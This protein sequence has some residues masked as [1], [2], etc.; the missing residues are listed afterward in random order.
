MSRLVLHLAGTVP[1]LLLTIVAACGGATG[2]GGSGVH[3]PLPEHPLGAPGP[4][5]GR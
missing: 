4:Q 3:G 1:V 5:A 2:G